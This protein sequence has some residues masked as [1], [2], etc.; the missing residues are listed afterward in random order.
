MDSANAKAD[1][2]MSRTFPAAI[3]RLHDELK[4]R[5]YGKAWL[6]WEECHHLAVGVQAVEQLG[7]LGE[8]RVVRTVEPPGTERRHRAGG[9]ETTETS[10]EGHTCGSE[11]GPGECLRL[12][13]LVY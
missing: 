4:W 6:A 3:K 11:G 9:F 2:W 1:L 13:V 5:M 10:F 8:E 7:D 12:G